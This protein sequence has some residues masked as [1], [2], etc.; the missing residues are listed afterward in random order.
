MGVVL[1][2]RT[3]FAAASALVLV[4]C[5]ST[6]VV[7]TQGDAFMVAKQSAAGIF[8]TPDAVMAEIFTEANEHCAKRGLVVET[9]KAETKGAIPF[10]RTGSASL[11]FRCVKAKVQA[12][13]Q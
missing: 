2:L 1:M 7:P 4:G 9:V 8:G 13:P 12:V 3:H 11:E 6:G 5:A 10:V